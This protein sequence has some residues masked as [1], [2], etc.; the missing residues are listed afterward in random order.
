MFLPSLVRD[1][2]VPEVAD[3]AITRACSCCWPSSAGSSSS[4]RRRVAAPRSPGPRRTGCRRSAR[5]QIGAWFGGIA[6]F[7]SDLGT[8][9]IVGAGVPAARRQAAGIPT[10]ARVRTRLDVVAG[11][12]PDPVHR[13]GRVHHERDRQRFRSRAGSPINEWDAFVAAI[14]VPILCLA[15]DRDRA[16]ADVP[17]LR[18]WAHGRSPRK[19]PVTTCSSGGNVGRRNRERKSPGRS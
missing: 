15:R 7:F 5:A 11:R 14:P 16:D 6:I 2:L 9:L 4:S 12:Y 10:E 13:L 18:L 3:S 17:P 19:R 1:H 8:P